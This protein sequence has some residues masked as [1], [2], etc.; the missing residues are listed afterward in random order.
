VLFGSRLQ[1]PFSLSDQFDAD[2]RRSEDDHCVP[3]VAESAVLDPGGHPGGLARRA[4]DVDVVSMHAIDELITAETIACRP[5]TGQ[6][7]C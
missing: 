5:D 6:S 1:F 2:Q 7:P 3:P 4:A